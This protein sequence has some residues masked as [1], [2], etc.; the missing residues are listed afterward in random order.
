VSNFPPC[1]TCRSLKPQCLTVQVVF[2]I[3]CWGSSGSSTDDFSMSVSGATVGLL[4]QLA[5]QSCCKSGCGVL[6]APSGFHAIHLSIWSLSQAF[7]PCRC[8]TCSSHLCFDIS[9]SSLFLNEVLTYKVVFVIG[10]IQA[11][12]CVPITS[13]CCCSTDLASILISLELLWVAVC[14][15]HRPVV[16]SQISH[17]CRKCFSSP[18]LSRPCCCFKLTHTA[19]PT[20]V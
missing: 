8:L 2:V 20:T 18:I 4:T 12:V 3:V 15:L 19:V 6:T 9:T 17:C 14:L 16:F 5:F 10:V 13:Q 7:R 1:S 11:E